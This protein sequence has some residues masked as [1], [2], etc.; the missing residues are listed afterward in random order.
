M[1]GRKVLAWG[2]SGGCCWLLSAAQGGLGK[3]WAGG[4]L[5]ERPQTWVAW[6]GSLRGQ[7]LLQERSGS[8]WWALMR[9]L[10]HCSLST[11]QVREHRVQ[12]TAGSGCW[13]HWELGTS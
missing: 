3:K 1:L 10:F 11:H 7:G 9:S 13:E 6:Q 5:Q 12:E 2:G 8:R 4:R